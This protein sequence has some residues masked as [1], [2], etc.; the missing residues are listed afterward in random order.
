MGF[1]R[2]SAIE[3]IRQTQGLKLLFEDRESTKHPWTQS[4]PSQ[5]QGKKEASPANYSQNP[6]FLQRT[7]GTNKESLEPNQISVQAIISSSTTLSVFSVQNVGFCLILIV[8]FTA[9]LEARRVKHPYVGQCSDPSADHEAVLKLGVQLN[10]L[11][12]G[13]LFSHHFSRYISTS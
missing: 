11:I 7:L 9:L 8:W 2:V 12:Q 5:L 13:F 3:G 10:C 1:R 4:T 6:G